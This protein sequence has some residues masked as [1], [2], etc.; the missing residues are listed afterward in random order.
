MWHQGG[1]VGGQ[2]ACAETKRSPIR[3][4][5]VPCIQTKDSRLAVPREGLRRRA[6]TLAL[7]VARVQAAGVP[8]RPFGALAGSLTH[9]VLRRRGLLSLSF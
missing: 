1:Q 9:L 2:D 7:A 6:R 8:G 5:A 4:A 3:I